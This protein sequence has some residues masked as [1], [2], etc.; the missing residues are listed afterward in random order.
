MQKDAAGDTVFVPH[1]LPSPGT[2]VNVASQIP[3]DGQFKIC[4]PGKFSL[5]RMSCDKHDYKAVTI[6]QAN[7]Q[8]TASDCKVYTIA[9][10]YQ[11][12]GYIGSAK[13]ECAATSR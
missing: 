2:C 12:H 5:S 4:G 13:Y 6:E 1:E 3:E 7:D 9:D 10:F 11:V 8:F